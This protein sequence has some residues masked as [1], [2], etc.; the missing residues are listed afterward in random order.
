MN[1][2][3]LIGIIFLVGVLFIAMALGV[4]IV[5]AQLETIFFAVA[6]ATFLICL[7]LG[8]RIWLILPLASSL[9]L[10]FRVPGQPS[11]LLI[12]QLLFICITI[13]MIMVRKINLRFRIGELEIWMI[14]LILL[15][16]QVYARNPVS[17]GIVGGDT[18]GGKAYVFFAIACIVFFL[19]SSYSVPKRQLYWYLWLSILGGILNFGLN[20]IGRLIPSVGFWYGAVSGFENEAAGIDPDKATRISFIGYTSRDISLW[21]STFIS[22]LRANLPSSLMAADY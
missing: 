8:S 15:V 14:A 9:G 11:A 5:T 7:L 20:V 18:V 2:R 21:V 10:T 19:L 3:S 6:A 12:A 16:G 17:V 1:T 4:Q 22:P 13:L